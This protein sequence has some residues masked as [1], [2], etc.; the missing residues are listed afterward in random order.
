[1]LPFV[2]GDSIALQNFLGL[3]KT[4]GKLPS[5]LF[6]IVDPYTSYCFNE[7]C[8]YI[9]SRLDAGDKIVPSGARNKNSKKKYSSFSELYAPYNKEVL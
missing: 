4:S 7:A 9:L 2:K 8:F 6:G 1:M 3:V 5:E